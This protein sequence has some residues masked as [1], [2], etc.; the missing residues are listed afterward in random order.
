MV[1]VRY[2][3]TPQ[4]V[5]LLGA[6]GAGKGTQA[7]LLVKRH[8]YQQLAT[9]DMFRDQIRRK[10]EL[11]KLAKSLID[12]GNFV[13]DDVT[14][15]MVRDV[16]THTPSSTPIVF[17][18]FPRTLVQVA[19][20]TQLEDESARVLGAVVFLEVEEPTLIS[21][22]RTRQ[23]CRT[24]GEVYSPQAHPTRVAGVCDLCGGETGARADETVEAITHRIGLFHTEVDPVVA[25]YGR[26]GRLATISGARDIDAVS[27]RLE[28][29]ITNAV[30]W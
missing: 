4:D 9:G 15:A 30:N 24:C 19:A 25:H 12:D 7:R 1:E 8:G 18:G 20:L 3:N 10:T 27:E 16:L 13:P 28:R 22:L 21:R 2:M 26:T 14:I 6:P 17:D 29:A 11:G 23:T 5:V